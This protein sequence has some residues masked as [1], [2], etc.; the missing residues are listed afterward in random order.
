MESEVKTAVIVDNSSGV[1]K[2]GFSGE[3]A[4]KAIFS[5]IVGRNKHSTILDEYIGDEAQ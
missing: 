3:D 2:A 1:I 5:T 4:P